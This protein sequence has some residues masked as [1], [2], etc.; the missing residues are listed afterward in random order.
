LNVIPSMWRWLLT[1]SVKCIE[2]NSSYDEAQNMNAAIPGALQG[3]NE[4]DDQHLRQT[5]DKNNDYVSE[6]ALLQSLQREASKPNLAIRESVEV[7]TSLAMMLAFGVLFPPLLIVI[8]FSI[9]ME[10]IL[11]R[12]MIGLWMWL[13]K[14]TA[15]LQPVL[16]R[17]LKKALHSFDDQWHSFAKTCQIGLLVVFFLSSLVWSF[18]LFDTLGDEVGADQAYWILLVMNLFPCIV[19]LFMLLIVSAI[20]HNI[21]HVMKPNSAVDQQCD[22]EMTLPTITEVPN[23]KET[24]ESMLVTTNPMLSEQSDSANNKE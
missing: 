15:S 17:Q 19:L 3:S 23:S 20:Y 4:K 6:D 7:M 1:C 14:E 24:N 12:L 8:V 2:E 18:S 22:I 5:Q 13:I 11:F 21:N 16:S 9:C 10:V